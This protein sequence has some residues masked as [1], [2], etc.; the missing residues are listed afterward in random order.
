MSF[1]SGEK[2]RQVQDVKPSQLKG[3]AG[4]GGYTWFINHL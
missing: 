1:G 4:E 3:G 2:N